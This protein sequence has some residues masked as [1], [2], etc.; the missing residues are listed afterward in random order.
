MYLW[1]I[2]YI[3]QTASKDDMVSLRIKD[4]IYILLSVS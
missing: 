3:L 2:A 4:F 1:C